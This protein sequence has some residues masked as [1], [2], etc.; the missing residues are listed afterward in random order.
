MLIT[1]WY[2]NVPVLSCFMFHSLYI[3]YSINIQCT[4]TWIYNIYIYI[5]IYLYIYI[6]FTVSIFKIIISSTC[7]PIQLKFPAAPHVCGSTLGTG[8]E[9]GWSKRRHGGWRDLHRSDWSNGTFSEV[10]WISWVMDEMDWGVIC[11]HIFRGLP[12]PEGGGFLWFGWRKLSILKL[13]LIVMNF[14]IS[15]AMNSW[16]WFTSYEF[17]DCF[18]QLYFTLY[19]LHVAELYEIVA[20][21]Q[22]FVGFTFS[23]YIER[24][25][26]KR[27]ILLMSQA[28]IFL[29]TDQT[30]ES[31]NVAGTGNIT[32]QT[33]K[34]KTHQN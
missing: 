28:M 21:A 5:L 8:E 7:Q 30:L 6:I 29:I 19:S 9:R 12:T 32:F 22:E 1:S 34:K 23:W 10:S 16:W 14:R 25:G 31:W 17:Q 33:T 20:I 24:H 2:L 11:L 26:E 3:Y 18:T 4:F 13:Y 27:S 15:Q